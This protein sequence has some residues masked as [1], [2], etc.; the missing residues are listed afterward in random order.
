MSHGQQA[1]LE[2][3]YETETQTQQIDCI[4]FPSALKEKKI[5]KF[6]NNHYPYI[7]HLKIDYHHSTV[8]SISSNKQA[9]EVIKK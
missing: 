7:H 4:E 3:N 5:P 1:A 9:Y 2:S 6:G 8:V